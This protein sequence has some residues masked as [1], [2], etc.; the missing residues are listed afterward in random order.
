MA[1]RGQLSFASA[2]EN[3][4]FK[5]HVSLQGQ[6]PSND[7]SSLGWKGRAPSSQ[8]RITLRTTPAPNTHEVDGDSCWFFI[9]DLLPLPGTV[10]APSFHG[11]R[12]GMW[13][14]LP[15]N[16]QLTD[17]HRG[18][19]TESFEIILYCFTGRVKSLQ[20]VYRWSSISTAFT[21]A[22]STKRNVCYVLWMQNPQIGGPAKELEHPL[23]LVSAG[24]LE[25]I[26]CRHGSV[27]WM[28]VGTNFNYTSLAFLFLLSCILLLNML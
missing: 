28:F 22:D 8:L 7:C 1:L 9:T 5:A 18:R 3:Y 17:P 21:S 13:R 4:L 19:F 2:E 26:P 10:S 12:V 6:S 20:T 11:W 23:D 24:V 14:A 16:I 15:T 25:L 27:S